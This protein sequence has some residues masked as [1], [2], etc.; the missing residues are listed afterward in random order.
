M[1][2][3]EFPVCIFGWNRSVLGCAIDTIGNR[4]RATRHTWENTASALRPNDLS[5]RGL[6]SR[7][8]S[9]IGGD[10][11]RAHPMLRLSITEAECTRRNA[12][13][14]STAIPGRRR[15]NWLRIRLST[16]C[17]WEHTVRG[18]IVLR[19]LLCLRVWVG[20]ERRGRQATH[21]GV[22]H[23]RRSRRRV[24]IMA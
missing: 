16:R 23:Y 13:E 4:S 14:I 17:R 1:R 9:T 21:T 5:S 12:I 24:H 20:E 15:R 2:A 8:G 22:R 3:G 18:G 6:L 10:W 7:V 11:V 19:R